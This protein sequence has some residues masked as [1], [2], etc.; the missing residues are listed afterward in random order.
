MNFREGET[1]LVGAWLMRDGRVVSDETEQRITRLVDHELTKAGM[2][3][4]SWEVLYR[5]PQDGRY[6]ELYFPKGY[7][8]GGAPQALRL[9][10]RDEVQRKYGI[11]E[12]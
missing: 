12:R 5:D 1:E 8:Q 3:G 9:L 7:L 4:G 10:D 6:W 11:S 2:A